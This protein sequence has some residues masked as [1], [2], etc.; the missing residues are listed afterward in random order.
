[1]YVKKKK[2]YPLTH[3]LFNSGLVIFLLLNFNTIELI[4]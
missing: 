2:S 1:M 3:F 4:I